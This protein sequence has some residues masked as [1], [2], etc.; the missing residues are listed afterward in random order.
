MLREIV[1]KVLER[2]VDVAHQECDEEKREVIIDELEHEVLHDERIIV[3]RLRA[4]V[5]PLLLAR[6]GPRAYN[7]ALTPMLDR[8]SCLHH[9]LTLTRML[10]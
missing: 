4:V 5:L 10:E 1:P 8:P 7:T 6:P 3:L 2:D 9:C